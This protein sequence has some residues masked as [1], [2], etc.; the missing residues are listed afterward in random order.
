MTRSAIGMPVVVTVVVAVPRRHSDYRGRSVPVQHQ[1]AS[2]GPVGVVGDRGQLAE[3]HLREG[4]GAAPPDAGST[5]SGRPH[6]RALLREQNEA[7]LREPA[8][9][10]WRPDLVESQVKTG[11]HDQAR[12]SLRLFPAADARRPNGHWPSRRAAA[13]LLAGEGDYEREFRIAL[14]R[15][16]ST[17]PFKRA[18][19]E[20]CFGERIR[21]SRRRSAALGRLHSALDTFTRIGANPWADRAGTGDRGGRQRGAT[22][23]FGRCPAPDPTGAAGGP[24]G[25]PRILQPGG[26]GGLVAQREAMRAHLDR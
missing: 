19:T 22:S 10:G 8:V 15:H 5:G 14:D 7:G 4:T 2:A 23:W 20:L 1:L 24:A 26:R 16:G 18:R 21:R 17:L 6:F 25:L 9:F 11:R 3:L 12:Q 13:G